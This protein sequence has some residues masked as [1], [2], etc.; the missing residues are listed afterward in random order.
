VIPTI[1]KKGSTRKTPLEVLKALFSAKAGAWVLL[2]FAIEPSTRFSPSRSALR[3]AV[4]RHREN[5]WVIEE[6]EW[7]SLTQ[8]EQA[9]ANPGLFTVAPHSTAYRLE[10]AQ[11]K[12]VIAEV[13]ASKDYEVKYRAHRAGLP[14]PRPRQ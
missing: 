14:V 9:G 3:M 2:R 10:K 12:E 6:K 11:R 1:P 4:V 5:G 13:L 7:R 8:K